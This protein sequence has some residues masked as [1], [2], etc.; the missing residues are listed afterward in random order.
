MEYICWGFAVESWL[1]P[2]AVRCGALF[3]LAEG[4]REVSVQ[5]SLQHSWSEPTHTWNDKHTSKAFELQSQGETGS[6]I[7]PRPFHSK[8][9]Q[10]TE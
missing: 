2:P 8:T 3:R 9:L 4:R 6:D 1:R 10:P 5:E 7:T